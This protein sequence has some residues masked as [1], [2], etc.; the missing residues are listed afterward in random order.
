MIATGKLKGLFINCIEAQCSIFESGKMVFQ[1]LT[2]SE[3]FLLDY[4]EVDEKRRSIPTAYDFYLFNYHPVTMSWLD[5]RRIRSVLPGVKMTVVL[6]VSPNDPFVYC[7]P[8]DFDAYCVLDPTLNVEQRN[9][10]AFPRPLE[11][12]GEIA[13]PIKSD[14]PVI[15]SFGFATAGKG[16]EHVIDAVNKEFDRALVRI[17]I[18]FATYADESRSF[19]AQLAELCRQKAKNGVE[20]VVNHDFMSK[21]ELIRWCAENTLNCFLYDRKMPGLAATTDQAIASGRPLAISKNDTFRH[22]QKYIKP[23]PYQ[24]LRQAIENTSANVEQIRRDWSPQKFREQFEKTLETLNITRA[25]KNNLTIELPQIKQAQGKTVLRRALGK[26]RRAAQKLNA[27]PKQA[28][29]A[30][31][32][33]RSRSQYGE[34]LLVSNFLQDAKVQNAAYLDIFG[35]E[36][37]AFSSTRYFYDQDFKGVV[38]VPDPQSYAKLRAGRP[39]DAVLSFERLKAESATTGNI[40][41]INRIIEEYFTECPDFVS[42]DSHAW[43]LKILQALDFGKY[44]PAVFLIGKPD[45]N[46]QN[47]ETHEFFER[48]GYFALYETEANTIFVNKNLYEFHLYQKERQKA[49]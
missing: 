22:V 33:E 35:G 45:S 38:I 42:I 24:T 31:E 5:T 21:P 39:R 1:C 43:D 3:E 40:I 49:V 18:P 12:L 7:S 17:N 19:A 25:A 48:S 13:T 44:N 34:D 4:I 36:S 47:K 29:I 46:S 27:A 14:L 32:P 9:V 28:S 10:F 26:L 15:G 6:E 30:A 23:F 2:G 16:F 11:T 20:V 8:D 37:K 41:N